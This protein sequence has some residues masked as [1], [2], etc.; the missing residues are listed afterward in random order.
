M[1]CVVLYT[2]CTVNCTVDNMI[3]HPHKIK[4]VPVKKIDFWHHLSYLFTKLIMT[5]S[6]LKMEN[7]GIFYSCK[8]VR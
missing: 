5:Y 3:T 7:V 1:L 2:H 8:I 4:K 6:V